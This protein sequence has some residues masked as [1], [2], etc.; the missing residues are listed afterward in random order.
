MSSHLNKT[1]ENINY[2]NYTTSSAVRWVS[3]SASSDSLAT[4]IRNKVFHVGQKEPSSLEK[5]KRGT[6]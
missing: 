1:N 4:I 6:H 2:L 5:A 3:S